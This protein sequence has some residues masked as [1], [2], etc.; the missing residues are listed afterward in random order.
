MATM[1]KQHY[2]SMSDKERELLLKVVSTDNVL[3]GMPSFQEWCAAQQSVHWTRLGCAPAGY[4]YYPMALAPCT[5][6]IQRRASNASHWAD[7]C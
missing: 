4:I 5:S 3:R 7:T 6:N 2:E 1:T